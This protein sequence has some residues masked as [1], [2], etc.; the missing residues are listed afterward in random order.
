MLHVQNVCSCEKLIRHHEF[1]FH[2]S[3]SGKCGWKFFL[4]NCTSDLCFHTKT[5]SELFSGLFV[6]PNRSDNTQVYQ[7]A[8]MCVFKKFKR[9]KYSKKRFSF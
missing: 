6:T 5:P 3:H 7:L 4:L 8:M 9:N 1:I 2:E